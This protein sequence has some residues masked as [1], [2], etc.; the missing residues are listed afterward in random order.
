M[1]R[2]IAIFEDGLLVFL[3]S[4]MILVAALQIVLR[5]FFDLGLSWGDQTLRILV[6]W[7]ALMGAVAAS[8][9]NKHINIDVLL[10]F[11]TVRGR[12]LSQVV[13]GGFTA[14]I[15]GFVAYYAGRFVFLDYEAGTKIYGNVPAWV[16]EIILPAGFA[17]ISLRYLIFAFQQWRVF[18]LGEDKP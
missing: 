7:V 5:N 18:V 2:W 11:L 8:R 16:V 3:L 10:R 15:C 9:E 6:L 12:A 4:A 13:V 17:L 14:L 1:L